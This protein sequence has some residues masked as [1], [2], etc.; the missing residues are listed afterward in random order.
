MAAWGQACIARPPALRHR[1]GYATRTVKR[2]VER[3]T[4]E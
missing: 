1:A 4:L 3:T 2:G